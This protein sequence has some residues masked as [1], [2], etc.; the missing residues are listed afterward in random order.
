MD[1]P[2]ET[3]PKKRTVRASTPTAKDTEGAKKKA[4]T[5]APS[6]LVLLK[7]WV[8]NPLEALTCPDGHAINPGGNKAYIY[9]PT[10]FICFATEPGTNG[11]NVAFS[12]ANPKCA[13]KGEDG[14]CPFACRGCTT[15]YGTASG[16][17]WLLKNRGVSYGIDYVNRKMFPALVTGLVRG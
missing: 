16:Y 15:L 7:K 12:C 14:G 11:M 6:S 17:I 3:D 8:P 9:K 13:K 2:S 1:V 5:T 10:C 4:K